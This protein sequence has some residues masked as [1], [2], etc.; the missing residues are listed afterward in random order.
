MRV[1]C[2]IVCFDFA[3]LSCARRGHDF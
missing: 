1:V 2:L 3:V